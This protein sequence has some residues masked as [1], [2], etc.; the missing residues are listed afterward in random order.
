[1]KTGPPVGNPDARYSKSGKPVIIWP[2]ALGMHNW[3]PMAYSPETGYVYIP[4]TGLERALCRTGQFRLQP[5]RLEHRHRLRRRRLPLHQAR[6]PAR[7]ATSPA[8]SSPG[9]R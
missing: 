7:A 2:A 1:M 8:T 4:V 5:D 6:R 9:I 3:H